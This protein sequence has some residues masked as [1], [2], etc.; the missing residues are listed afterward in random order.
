MQNK[1]FVKVFAGITHPCMCVLSFFLF[2][3]PSITWTKRH[4][5]PKGEAHYL[6]SM[7]NEKVYLGSYS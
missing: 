3:D 5:D 6:D 1:G 7:Q 4:R 2:C